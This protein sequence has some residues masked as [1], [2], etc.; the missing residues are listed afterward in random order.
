LYG[1]AVAVDGVD[2]DVADGEIVVLLGPSGCGKTSVLR[3]V[4][5]LTAASDGS[6]T[7]DGRDIRGVPAHARGVGLMFQDFALFPHRDV[8]GNVAFGPRMQGAN[9]AAASARVAEVLDLV[10]LTGFEPRSVASLSGGEQQRVAL[11]RALAPSPRL[12]LL[13]EPLGSLDRALRERLTAELRSL[14]VELGLSVV[15]VTHDQAEAFTLA[16]RVVVLRAG[17]VVQAGT[18]SEVWRHPADGFVARFLGFANVLNVVVSAGTANT[19]WGPLVAER[20]D[21]PSALVIRPDGLT[22]TAAGDG[23]PGVAG[24]ATFRGDHFLVPVALDSGEAVEVTVRESVPP[25]GGQ[26]TVA[27]D[28]AATVF[29]AV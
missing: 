26:V 14:F 5:G 24:P 21:G 25:D 19:P 28:R 22:L 27:L 9:R 7:L 23:A 10:G 12:L 16:D 2:L 17:R 13:D 3:A 11:A 6:I 20:G 29:T 4:A 15:T 18:P 1:D 8:A